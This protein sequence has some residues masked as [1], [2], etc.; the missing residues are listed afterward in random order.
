M[1]TDVKISLALIL[2]LAGL[3]PSVAHAQVVV[4]SPISATSES[5]AADSENDKDVTTKIPSSVKSVVKRLG[6]SE[7]EAT[8]DD[9][10]SAREA[11]A[12]LDLM[13]EIEKR[14]KELSNIKR[15]RSEN[16]AANA[17]PRAVIS[18]LPM[19]QLQPAAV[20]P[21]PMPI[22]ADIEVMRIT[23]AEG[24]NVAMIKVNGST[25]KVQEGD[26][27]SDGSI[28]RAVTN[29]SIALSRDGRER[30]YNVKNVGAIYSA[31]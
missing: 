28:V 12:K 8:L 5:A 2:G 15:D 19:A 6:V 20:A 10:N 9:L 14:L 18:P 3:V 11:V 13:I 21:P 4:S 7:N 17:M 26:H 16:G 1:K 27:M 29:R 22:A 30:T 24:H 23:G 31:R 25:T